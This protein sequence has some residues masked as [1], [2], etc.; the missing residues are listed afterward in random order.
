MHPIALGQVDLVKKNILKSTW[1]IIQDS[2]VRQ[3][4]FGICES[5]MLTTLINQV[6]LNIEDHWEA[7]I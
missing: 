1:E 2:E 7:R 4:K 5:L 3:I 6:F